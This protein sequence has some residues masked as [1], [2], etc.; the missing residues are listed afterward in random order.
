MASL[1]P[2]ALCRTFNAQRKY[3][4]D[5]KVQHN[6]F[7][8]I[9][10]HFQQ[11]NMNLVGWSQPLNDA[12]I[13]MVMLML[14]YICNVFC[15]CLAYIFQ[16]KLHT[17]DV[18]LSALNFITFHKHVFVVSIELCLACGSVQLGSVLVSFSILLSNWTCTYIH[19]SVHPSHW[20][21]P[22]VIPNE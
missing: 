7:T 5:N 17:I 2:P 22:T 13:L 15:M 11:F 1:N 18:K 4:I 8:T 19:P 20:I 12:L 14:M 3:L 10:S 21:Y 9:K 16:N 6:S